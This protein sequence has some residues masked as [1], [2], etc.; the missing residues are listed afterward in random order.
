MTRTLSLLLSPCLLTIGLAACGGDK[1]DSSNTDE[2]DA[3]TDADTDTDTDTDADTDADTDTDPV[4]D[5][6]DYNVERSAFFGDL[7]VH[8]SYSF[9]AFTIGNYANDPDGAYRFAKGEEIDIPPFNL[10]GT[11]VDGRT[12]R[13]RAPLDFAGVTDH[14][15]FLGET[16]YC[17]E[18]PEPGFVCGPDDVREYIYCS[19]ECLQLRT[20]G[21][22][23]A[24]LNVDVSLM[25]WGAFLAEDDPDYVDAI[26]DNDLNGVEEE[27]D[28]PEKKQEV[29]GR[30]Q[31]ITESHNDPCTFTTF[32]AY[33]WSRA[34]GDASAM[35]HRN[36]IF[37]NEHIIEEP[38]TV[39]ETPDPYEMLR[40]VVDGCESVDGC[41]FMAI[42]HNSN[43]TFGLMYQI[44]DAED[45]L[46]LTDENALLRAT[47]EPLVEVMQA[48]GSSE[49]KNGFS[50]FAA[51]DDE[52]CEFEDE[53]GKLCGTEGA[54][55]E[56]CIDEC[57]PTIPN[58]ATNA[59]TDEHGVEHEAVKGCQA[60]NDYLRNT[61]KEGLVQSERL[62]FNPFEQGF[63][64][65]TDTHN[66]MPGATLER[67]FAGSHGYLDDEAREQVDPQASILA[68]VAN[69]GG[70]AGVWAEENTRASIFAAMQ[71]KETF[72]TSGTRITTRFFGGFDLPE[73]LCDQPDLVATAYDSGVPM[74][75]TLS[76]ATSDAPRF[77]AWAARAPDTTGEDGSVWRGTQLQ[78]I[79]V[80]KVWQDVSGET[81]ERVYD[82]TDD[83]DNGASVDEAT[84]APEGPGADELCAVWTDPAFDPAEKAIYYTRVLENPSCRYT[85][86]VC[87]ENADEWDCSDPESDAYW[88]GCCD[89]AIPKT[90]QERAWASPI[91]YHPVD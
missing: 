18:P 36:I 61:M 55:P 10:D 8:S 2:A 74:G 89:P 71:R 41:E 45:G 62:G 19:T 20:T 21:P 40:R 26:C 7:H 22:V 33:E 82:I 27:V 83:P 67:E 25:E 77:L 51:E 68:N 76:A 65:S 81:H 17:R 85:G 60:S 6:G 43:L 50:L 15:E 79:Q 91:F 47:Y 70:L 90:I 75:G 73:D 78:R 38:V 9:D 23:D 48:K 30:M 63:I 88:D 14:A 16:T 39:L 84:C 4:G 24:G 54:D 13:L 11:P 58:T 69:P 64:G 52:F 57:D 34:E 46:L 31:G 5:C 53:S 56:T 44:E 72:A 37:A 32:H 86:H 29:W 80:I 3:D 12:A 66:G 35:V 49:C 59:Y 28:C 87:A 42:P 1:A